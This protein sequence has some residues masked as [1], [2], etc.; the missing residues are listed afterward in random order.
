MITLEVA[1][2]DI[3]WTSA[4]MVSF[5]YE[6]PFLQEPRCLTLNDMA[7]SLRYYFLHLMAHFLVGLFIFLAPCP[8]SS[9]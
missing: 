9:F 2:I 7:T 5:S 8:L 4:G 6:K 3:V 1:F